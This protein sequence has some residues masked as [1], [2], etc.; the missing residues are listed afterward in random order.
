MSL[1]NEIPIL[2]NKFLLN[3]LVS[4]DVGEDYLEE[5]NIKASD[6]SHRLIILVIL[7][8]Y[9]QQFITRLRNDSSVNE[10]D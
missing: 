6:I 8:N 9:A 7:I 10:I 4:T 2:V 3:P 5:L 1:C